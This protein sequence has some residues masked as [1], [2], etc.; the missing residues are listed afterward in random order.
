[1]SRKSPSVLVAVFL[2]S[3]SVAGCG[4]PTK[5][6]RAF[7]EHLAD[8]LVRESGRTVSD[9][10]RTK[11]VDKTVDACEAEPPSKQTLECAMKADSSDAMK[12]CET[13]EKK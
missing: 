3:A 8:V 7:A 4:G 2:A 12:A 13:D 6:C 1:M 10:D 9:D 5:E 11:M